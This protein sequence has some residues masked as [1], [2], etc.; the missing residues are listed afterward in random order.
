MNTGKV[1]S[2]IKKAKV[3]LISTHQNPDPDALCSELA[4]SIFLR[5]LGKKVHI[6]NTEDVPKRF[7]F[8]PQV[9]QIKAYKPTIKIDYDAALILDCGDLD[10]IEKVQNLLHPKKTII[11]I[12][13]HITNTQFGHINLV[14]EKASSTCE[15]LFELIREAK[16]KLTDDLAYHLYTGIMTDTGSFRYENT[17]AYT[18]Q[19]A[20][21]LRHYHFNA[22]D[23]YR[24][25]YES[26][27]LNNLLEAS[28]VISQME[29]YFGGKAIFLKLY[30]KEV[31]KFSEDMDLRDTL[32]KFLRLIKGV[33][34]FV[35]LTEIKKNETR[36][37][38][39]SAHYVD[40]AHIASHFG[41]GGHKRASGCVVNADMNQ[42][43]KEVLKVVRKAI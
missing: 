28:K 33:E 34:V 41:G 10:R 18:H 26:V 42:A 23:I 20:A 9:K 43:Q 13:H 5:Q 17:S 32:F 4:V 7:L 40:V 19:V 2:A 1:L 3:F 6:V 37:N 36:V 16:G 30:D 11:N 39:R 8:L 22:D 25:I 29:H 15:V 31:K 24:Q 12:D 35:I 38:F 14:K 21:E 27:P